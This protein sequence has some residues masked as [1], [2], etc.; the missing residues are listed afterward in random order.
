MSLEFL[1]EAKN[2]GN[3]TQ[4]YP[5]PLSAKSQIF[6]SSTVTITHGF[7]RLSNDN[8]NSLPRASNH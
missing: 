3:G 6:L 1:L 5:R 8:K 2:K 7:L 4:F